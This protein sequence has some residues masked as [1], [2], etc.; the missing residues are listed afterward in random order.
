MHSGLV[1]RA[2][3]HLFSREI[4]FLHSRKKSELLDLGFL[5]RG[6]PLG[7]PTWSYIVE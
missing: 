2:D 7:V 3:W 1:L 4:Y 6:S 5:G